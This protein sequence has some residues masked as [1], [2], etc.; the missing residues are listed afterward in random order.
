MKITSTDAKYVLELGDSKILIEDLKNE[1][2]ERILS[3]STISTYSLPNGEQWSP[4]IE[5]AKNVKR[6]ELPPEIKKA[7]RKLLALS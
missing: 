7:L 4:K 5:E 3:I 2:G 1:K 6:E